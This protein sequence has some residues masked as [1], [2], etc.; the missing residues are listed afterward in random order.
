MK[1]E[2]LGTELRPFAKQYELLTTEPS[3]I[4]GQYEP[5]LPLPKILFFEKDSDFQ[6]GF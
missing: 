1:L 5:F 3:V 6:F 4:Q 2:F